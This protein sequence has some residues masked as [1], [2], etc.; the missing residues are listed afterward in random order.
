MVLINTKMMLGLWICFWVSIIIANAIEENSPASPFPVFAELSK[1]VVI[2]CNVSQ[3]DLWLSQWER[4]DENEP[5]EII[6][7]YLAHFDRIDYYLSEAKYTFHRQSF[8]L[9]IKDVEF[10]DVATGYYKCESILSTGGGAAFYSNIVI[11]GK[12]NHHFVFDVT[13]SN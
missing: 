8:S 3:T 1:P 11:F 7:K 4:I 6:A 5:T 9:E 2:P 13:L 10:L 12:F